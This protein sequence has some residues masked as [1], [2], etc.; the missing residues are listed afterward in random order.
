MKILYILKK[1][2]LEKWLKNM[3][4]I[5]NV[6]LPAQDMK[7]KIVNFF[8]L[9]DINSD[10]TLD[11]E[12]SKRHRLNLSEK[13]KMSPKSILYS[14]TEK[15]FDFEYTKD[16]DKPDEVKIDIKMPEGIQ[17]GD[18]KTKTA[19]SRG[20][21]I[22]GIKPCDMQSINR[23]DRVFKESMVKD[24]YYI[25]KRENSIFIS[26]AC[27]IPFED[28]FCTMVGGNPFNFENSDMGIIEI[29]KDYAV[30]KLS[31]KGI[32]LVA[33]NSRFFENI[34]SE[35]EAIQYEILIE[36]NKRGAIEKISQ[37]WGDVNID[38]ISSSFKKS[39]D[40][41]VWKKISGKCISCGACTFVCPTCYCFDI[42]DEQENLKGERYRCWDY[43]MN[44]MYALEA[45][46]H[47]P[48]EDITK[49]YRNKVNC[50]YNYNY[51]RNGA[52]FCV[53]CGRCIEVCPV[54]MDIREV[55]DIFLSKDKS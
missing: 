40:V 34:D 19:G 41:S 1:E 27:N 2:N 54:D 8:N 47:N 6:Y 31:K 30:V 3:G 14:Q 24:P 39:F 51:H 55:V 11:T 37:L 52:L 22:F 12:D 49:R 44:F 33:E 10:F 48:R 13:T 35:K 17:S 29:D 38:S 9:K 18:N 7:E 53:G 42:R 25:N 4:K 28:C 45:S 32:N 5:Y 15:L 23:M 21:V 26:V 36:K 46:G 16:I 20:N 50:K 43:C